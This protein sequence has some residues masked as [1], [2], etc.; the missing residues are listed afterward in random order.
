MRGGCIDGEPEFGDMVC[1]AC[2][3][4]LAE[5]RGIASRFRVTPE[6]VN[7]PLQ[8]ITPSGRTW[9]GCRWLW[10]GGQAT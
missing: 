8:T 6:V 5:E 4:V 3:M 1:A 7:V 9:D 2:F 10:R